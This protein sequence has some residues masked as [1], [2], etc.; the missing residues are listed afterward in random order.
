MFSFK[1]YPF[2]LA[3]LP[4]ILDNQLMHR[5]HLIAGIVWNGESIVNFD[6]LFEDN[7]SGFISMVRVQN[8]PFGLP[9]NKFLLPSGIF[10]FR[11]MTLILVLLLRLVDPSP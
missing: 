3:F 4:W 10:Q 9:V 1:P 2:S 8:V 7:R 5:H 6:D 11:V